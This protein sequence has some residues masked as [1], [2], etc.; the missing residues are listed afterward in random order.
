MVKVLFFKNFFQIGLGIKQFDLRFP[1]TG[2]FLAA[3]I[4]GILAKRTGVAAFPDN[5]AGYPAEESRRAVPLLG[6][7]GNVIA[8]IIQ[9]GL[10]SG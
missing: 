8:Q 3:D 2:A 1:E 5:P 4:A 6:K 10:L 7:Q 9:A